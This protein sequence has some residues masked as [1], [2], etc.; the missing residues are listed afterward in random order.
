MSGEA[1]AFLELVLRDIHNESEEGH[2][3]ERVRAQVQAEAE[4]PKPTAPVA[5]TDW[6]TFDCSELKRI[7]WTRAKQRVA[8]HVK[9][10]P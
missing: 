1:R 10:Q 8:E 9:G 2:A 6:S 3:I 4:A 5:K 7:C